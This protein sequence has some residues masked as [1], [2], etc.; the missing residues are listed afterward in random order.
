MS[1]AHYFDN[2]C[3]EKNKTF[4]NLRSSLLHHENLQKIEIP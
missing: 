1:H 2:Q 3:Q 4:K